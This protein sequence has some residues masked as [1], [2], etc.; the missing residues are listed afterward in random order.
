MVA[1]GPPGAALLP[2]FTFPP[3]MDTNKDLTVEHNELLFSPLL[4]I[5]LLQ[6]KLSSR[7]SGAE[8]FT[9]KFVSDNLMVNDFSMLKQLKTLKLLIDRE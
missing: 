9:I 5:L 7:S 1:T 2:V 8:V 3:K 6:F 4:T